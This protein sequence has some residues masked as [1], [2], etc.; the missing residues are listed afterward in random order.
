MAP[1]PASPFVSVVIP[2]RGDDHSL[3]RCLEGLRKQTY[4]RHLREVL[5]VLNELENRVLEVELQEGE[6]PLWQPHYFSYNARNLGVTHATGDIIA[7]T[8]S[9]TIPDRNWLRAG[10]DAITSGADLVAGQIDLKFSSSKLTPAACY[11]KLFAFDQEKNVTSGYSTAANLFVRSSLVTTVGLFDEHAHTGEDFAWTRRAAASGA[12]L[13]YSQTAIVSHP[14]RESMGELFTKAQRTSSFFMRA[15]IATDQQASIL[16]D[17]LR[18]QLLEAPSSSKRIAM[19]PTELVLAHAVRLILI[20]YKALR[21]LR[22]GLAPQT[23]VP[24]APL[25]TSEARDI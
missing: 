17:R 13:V 6:V 16:R 1:L 9:D 23:E 21:V 14:A 4:P 18:H 2:H 5:I 10:I 22:G 25:A 24:S 20:A 12:H 7:F 19:R 8:D 11:E 15:S 3:E